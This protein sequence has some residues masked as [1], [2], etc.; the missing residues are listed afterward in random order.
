MIN[1]LLT[2]IF[3]IIMVLVEVVLSP[4]DALI[5]AAFPDL[6]VVI[7][8]IGTVFNYALSYIN[9]L[10]SCFGLSPL[11]IQILVLFYSFKLVVPFTVSAVKQ[12][13]KWY[14]ALKP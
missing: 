1:A 10:I 9:F 4:I 11:A 8:A 12:A 6:S 14:N 2:G 3:K 5:S 13:I 7:S